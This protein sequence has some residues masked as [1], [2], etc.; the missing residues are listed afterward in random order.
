LLGYALKC[1]DADIRAKYLP[2]VMYC[3][4]LDSHAQQLYETK[5]STKWG[6]IKNEKKY[7]D[8]YV[9]TKED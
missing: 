9:I 4:G 3:C 7:M 2:Y 5:H 1:L 6:L 8:E